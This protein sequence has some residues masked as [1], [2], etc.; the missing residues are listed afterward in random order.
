MICVVEPNKCQENAVETNT[1]LED[2]KDKNKLCI[3]NAKENKTSK[4]VGQGCAKQVVRINNS[5]DIL[6]IIL[7][8]DLYL[9]PLPFVRASLCSQTISTEIDQQICSKTSTFQIVITAS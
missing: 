3:D 8:V 6:F 1:R 4:K 5:K 9:L 2:S 7:C